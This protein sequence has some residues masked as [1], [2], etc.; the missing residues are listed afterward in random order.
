MVHPA[1][2]WQPIKVLNVVAFDCVNLIDQEEGC[3]AQIDHSHPAAL[4]LSPGLPKKIS[5][6]FFNVTGI[7]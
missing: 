2:S 3:I 7:Y 4:G 1:G 6:E 5:L